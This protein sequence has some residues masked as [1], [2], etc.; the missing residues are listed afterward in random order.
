MSARISLPQIFPVGEIKVEDEE[1]RFTTYQDN[2]GD[3]LEQTE[4]RLEKAPIQS[5]V[6]VEGIHDDIPVIFTQG[7]DYT[8]SQTNSDI[9]WLD[10]G[11]HPDPGTTFE[12]TY[13]S[14]SVISRYIGAHEDEFRDLEDDIEEIRRAKFIDYAEGEELDRIGQIFGR[15]GQRLGKND[16][17]REP[18]DDEAYRV[19]LKSIVQSF[20]SRGTQ[21]DMRKAIAAANGI[22]IERVQLIEDFQGNDYE[23]VISTGT[24]LRSSLIEE[25]A[26]I[27]DP[28]GIGQTG[29]TFTVPP[30]T[31]TS[32]DSVSLSFGNK[33]F[34]GEFVAQDSVEPTQ[35]LIVWDKGD[36]NE[37]NY[38]GEVDEDIAWA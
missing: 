27:A 16:D 13:R 34:G 4:Y 14:E 1:H 10:G 28:S 17:S 30:D 36:W 8:L 32:S 21:N 12:V 24:P 31:A 7:E 23:V 25:I 11:R 26:D 20:V 19:Y 15:L 22:D 5:V 3:V 33:F 6:T 9:I 2:F 37:F 35:E 29:T 38:A 18:I